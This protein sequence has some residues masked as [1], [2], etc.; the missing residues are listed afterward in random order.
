MLL[1][2]P[3]KLTCMS[4]SVSPKVT[5]AVTASC[6]MTTPSS[7]ALARSA[8]ISPAPPAINGKSSVYDLP[9][10]SLPI[11]FLT[12]PSSISARAYI[13][14]SNV[15]SRVMLSSSLADIPSSSKDS[16]A[17]LLPLNAPSMVVDIFLMPTSS[18]PISASVWIAAYFQ[19]CNSSAPIPV[20][21]DN[22]SI[23]S[24][25]S[26]AFITRAVP[27]A[28]AAVPI[29]TTAVPTL[30]AP[31]AIFLNVPPVSSAFLFVLFSADI[32]SLSSTKIEPNNLKSS[33][34]HHPPKSS[35]MISSFGRISIFGTIALS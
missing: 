7:S 27:A 2:A 25:A 9:S 17:S 12:A 30:A 32:A 19:R 15:C 34:S 23:S 20:R 21:K 4:V 11:L 28:A 16:T 3:C 13:T 29:A 1:A 18:L 6:D 14:L 10:M 33:I 8:D 22:L 26:A 35:R 31:V 5:A 24:A